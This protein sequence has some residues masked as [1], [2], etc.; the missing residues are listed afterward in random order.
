MPH[1]DDMSA[2]LQTA[3]KGPLPAQSSLELILDPDGVAIDLSDY[4]NGR[5]SIRKG[6]SISPYSGIGAYQASETQ[7][8]LI[9]TSDIFNRNQITQQFYYA[10]S[11]L[12][13]NKL[14]G[15]SFIQVIKGDGGKFAAGKT[16]T[17]TEDG[18]SVD[19]EVSSVDETDPDFDQINF[20][21]NG[22]RA[23]GAGSVV[24]IQF[25]PGRKATFKTIVNGVAEKVDQ[26]TGILKGHPDLRATGA[27]MTFYDPL[28]TLLDVSLK[29]NG[30][31][32][33]L[34]SEGN[35]DTTLAYSRAEDPESDGAIDLDQVILGD[36]NLVQIGDWQIR[37]KNTS[38]DFIVTDPAGN[39]QQG[40]TATLFLMP[41]QGF[42]LQIPIAAWSG[43][44]DEDDE[45]TFSTTCSFG[46]PVNTYNSLPEMIYRCLIEGFGAGLSAANDLE[47]ASFT[48]LIAEYDEMFGAITFTQKTTV[49]KAIEVLQQHINGGLYYT[50]GGKIAISVYR[51][52]KE[53]PVIRSLSPDA[54]VIEL[55]QDDLGRIDRVTAEYAYSQ[56]TGKYERSVTVPSEETT[57]N[58]LTI[59]LPAFFSEAQAR[60]TAERIWVMWRKGVS[61]YS[62]T[63]KWG[64][65]LGLDVNDLLQVSSSHPLFAGRLVEIY[66]V[67]KDPVAQL[68]RIRA[69]DINYSFGQFLFL[70]VHN[71]DSGRV[72]W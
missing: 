40:N 57:G 5:V 64:Y 2:A 9:N 48:D 68:V 38:G 20:T 11:R 23:F 4:V 43:T 51:P 61:A 3:L 63:E 54:D 67:E 44:F 6:K 25:L 72:I 66:E 14:I 52:L 53:G 10:A 30:F 69:Y 19:F 13:V 32:K 71:L 70:D 29:A 7:V 22:G 8:S 31:V 42:Q 46:Q 50:N 58:L 12:L 55:Q 59:K 47:D 33:L 28:K 34:D 60:S 41:L 49:L 16:V 65:G 26:F 27:A 1:I 21:G 56:R 24:E 39:T 35:F 15:D 37:F 36:D 45:I 17:I 18:S 62:I